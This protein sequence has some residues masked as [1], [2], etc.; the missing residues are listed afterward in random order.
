[1]HKNYI[2]ILSSNFHNSFVLQFVTLFTYLFLTIYFAYFK[3]SLSPQQIVT[4]F[5]DG[6]LF[7]DGGPALR[8][9]C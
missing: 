7:P 8:P 5:A 6:A 9:L 2:Y 4:L 3:F 1:M